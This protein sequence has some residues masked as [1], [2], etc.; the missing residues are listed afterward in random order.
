MAVA[1]TVH[2]GLIHVGWICYSYWWCVCIVINSGI[3]TKKKVVVH[4]T[5]TAVAIG[6]IHAV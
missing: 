5:C 6:A 1:D 4:S 2:V 3:A